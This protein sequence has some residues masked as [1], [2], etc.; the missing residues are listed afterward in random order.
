M[1]CL[2]RFQQ[3]TIYLP[4]ELIKRLR[5]AVEFLNLT[6]LDGCLDEVAHL[7][8]DGQ[9]LAADLRRKVQSYDVEGMLN[10]LTE[11]EQTMR[12]TINPKQTDSVTPDST[13]LRKKK[14]RILIVDDVPATL[15]AIRDSFRRR[16]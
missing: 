2:P 11:I 6:E 14:A 4:T 10:I 8:Y 12:D 5:E 15:N 9:Q 3:P 13:S 1:V 7:G 16:L